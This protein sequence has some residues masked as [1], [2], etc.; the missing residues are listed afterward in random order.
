[1]RADLHTHSTC[2]DGTET[3][4]ALLHLAKEKELF[5]LSITDH[6]TLEAYTP[7]FLVLAKK[8]GIRIIV[9][10]EI[11]SLLDDYNVHILAYGFDYANEGF[12]S[13]LESIQHSRRDRNK[14]IMDG[15][16]SRVRERCYTSD[17]GP[18]CNRMGT[19]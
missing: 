5:G 18:E 7:E 8:L 4:Q 14:K 19:G 1:M 16:G 15:V 11:S 9:G 13:F 2:S 17:C 10:S 12:K 3:P 6:D